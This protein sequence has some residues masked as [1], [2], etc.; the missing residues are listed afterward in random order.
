MKQIALLESITTVLQPKREIQNQYI[1]QMNQFN[2]KHLQNKPL[3]NYT[4]KIK[5]KNTHFTIRFW[6]ARM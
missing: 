4:F 2:M 5:G 1:I 3:H 6:Q